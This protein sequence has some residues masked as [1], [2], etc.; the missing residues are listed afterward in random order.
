MPTEDDP[1]NKPPRPAWTRQ[2]VR[3]PTPPEVLSSMRRSP[4]IPPLPMA[5]EEKGGKRSS[6][7]PTPLREP[8]YPA[9]WQTPGVPATHAKAPTR[10]QEAP[11]KPEHRKLVDVDD[12]S[13]PPQSP[14]PPPPSRKDSPPQ[15]IAIHGKGWKVTVPAAALVAV[16]TAIG[17]W[18]GSRAV[19]KHESADIG[20]VITEV[21]ELRRDVKGLRRAVDGVAEEQA[22]ARAADRKILNYATDTFTPLVASMRKLGV[23]LQYAGGDD[24]AKEVEFHSAPLPGSNAPPIQP[25][26]ALPERPVL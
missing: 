21:R 20:D 13:M 22:D 5:K 23:K 18:F 6:G 26:V 3:Q 16:V 25:K 12:R 10:P 17:S 1:P 11:T 8:P 7:E 9:A 2:T 19:A 24:P 15:G 4:P 14:P